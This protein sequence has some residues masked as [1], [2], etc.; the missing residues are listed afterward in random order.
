MLV[1]GVYFEGG[2]TTEMTWRHR[3]EELQNKVK[4]AE[5]KS[6]QANEDIAKLVNEK[7]NK[8]KEVQVLIQERIREVEKKIDAD[9]RVDRE[10]I[11]ILN[12]A[13]KNQGAKK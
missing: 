12:D 1:V 5:V 11:D 13:A 4:E 9:C 3:V 10:A 8:T 2:Y 7:K 6:Q